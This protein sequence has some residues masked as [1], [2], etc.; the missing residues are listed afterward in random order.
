MRAST[1]NLGS[2]RFLLIN[3]LSN[4]SLTASSSNFTDGIG[5]TT[6]SMTYERV[7]TEYAETNTSS[8]I[9]A[10]TSASMD[11]E[12]KTVGWREPQLNR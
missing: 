6:T 10:A 5:G 1:S 11:T 2:D 7:H 4:D 3:S 8:Q 12:I 9:N